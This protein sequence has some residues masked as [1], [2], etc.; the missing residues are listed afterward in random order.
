VANARRLS[1]SLKMPVDP[2]NMTYAERVAALALDLQVPTG[3]AKADKLIGLM[4]HE[5]RS[6]VAMRD[7]AAIL[8]G[9]A[10]SLPA[11]ASMAATSTMSA[12]AKVIRGTTVADLAN[13]YRNEPTSSYR[14]LRFKTREFYD[15]LLKHILADCGDVNLAALNEQ[16]LRNRYKRWTE[17]GKTSMAHGQMT[18]LRTMANFVRKLGDA[19]ADR[20]AIT[21]HRMH[22]PA[23]KARNEAL[24][25]DQANLIRQKLRDMGFPSMSLA[26]ALQLDLELRQIDVIGQWVPVGEPGKSDVFYQ[27]QK[28]LRGL[29]WEEIDDDFILRH[30]TVDNRGEEVPIEV[31]LKRSPAV[32]EE[33]EREKQRKGRPVSGPVVVCENTGLPWTGIEFRKRWR[34]AADICG[35]P[36]TVKNMDSRMNADTQYRRKQARPGLRLVNS[37]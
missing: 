21:L 29:R 22:F 14:A 25:L 32:M 1:Y 9:V 5:L 36:K 20:L 11:A 4:Q 10:P 16:E 28:W 34:K 7:S 31:D 6:V 17:G 15:T 23:A 27:D 30:V 26:Q 19:D 33:L 37:T 13:R 18:M 12:N 35:V 3:I 8:H 2:A 24:T